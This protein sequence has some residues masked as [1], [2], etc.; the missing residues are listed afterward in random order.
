MSM[1]Y[2]YFINEDGNQEALKGLIHKLSTKAGPG[3]IIKLTGAEFKLVKSMVV[4]PIGPPPVNAPIPNCEHGEPMNKTCIQCG[5]FER[6]QVQ[7]G[8]GEA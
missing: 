6:A 4:V 5:R 7:P 2:M 1:Q 8:G 3:A